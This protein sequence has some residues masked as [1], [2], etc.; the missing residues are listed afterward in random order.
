MEP[1]A[2]NLKVFEY[3]EVSGYQ[4]VPT[5][6]IAKMDDFTLAIDESGIT[7][8]FVRC[9]DDE[10]FAKQGILRNSEFIL[11][12]RGVAYKINGRGYHSL[13]DMKKGNE[14]GFGGKSNILQLERK[15]YDDKYSLVERARSY[16]GDSTTEGFLYY[17]L[18]E[19]GYHNYSEFDESLKGG[20]Y[21]EGISLSEF[22]NAK[23][24]GFSEFTEYSEYKNS[25]FE[26]PERYRDAKALRIN[27]PELYNLYGL[28]KDLSTILNLQWYDKILVYSILGTSPS[29][30]IAL[31]DIID[32]FRKWE[33]EIVDHASN[34]HFPGWYSKQYSQ[35]HQQYE[36]EI[37]ADL[38]VTFS[39][40][41]TF[42]VKNQ[43]FSKFIEVPLF[44]D[45]NNIAWNNG[46]KEK[47]DKP[48]ANNL[49]TVIDHARK[50]GFNDIRV[51]TDANFGHIANSKEVIARLENDTKVIMVP[52]K[53]QADVFIIPFAIKDK[54]FILTNDTF[55]DYILEHPNDQDFI[56]THRVAFMIQDNQTV[57]S[58]ERQVML[59]PTISIAELNAVRNIF[60]KML[61]DSGKSTSYS[62][63][64]Y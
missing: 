19:L 42:D 6:E 63:N 47:G 62:L 17:Y 13:E 33:S 61:G 10:G 55:K 46:N 35:Y 26:S 41:G 44:I 27:N 58:N 51:Y 30:T 11:Y 45:G 8:I 5:I 39:G 34:G 23:E 14:L 18:I 60:D 48:D 54:G 43:T 3:I 36:K 37:E 28:L 2:D 1:K 31:E 29:K 7:R 32:Q 57:F 22:R 15:D 59:A 52:A 21:G 64:R 40:L 49:L 25:R 12:D 53:T 24:L 56:M 16:R 50:Y 38:A 9:Y 20:F 4:N